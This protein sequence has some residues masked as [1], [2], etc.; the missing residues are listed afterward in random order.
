MPADTY[1]RDGVEYEL[2]IV[3]HKEMFRATWTCSACHESGGL[4]TPCLTVAEAIGRA[5]AH[6][7]TA[8]HVPIH[9]LKRI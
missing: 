3:P 1:E 6:A 4:L 7:F 5:K 2:T 8:H 9:A